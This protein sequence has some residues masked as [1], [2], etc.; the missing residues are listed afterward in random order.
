L[1]TI[2]T[3]QAYIIEC[4]MKATMYWNPIF[5]DKIGDQ[6]FVNQTICFCKPIR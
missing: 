3:F 4:K 6:K 2:T 1:E 5:N